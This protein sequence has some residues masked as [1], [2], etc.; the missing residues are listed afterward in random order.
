MEANQSG[1]EIHPL[2]SV[3]E[4]LSWTAP[5]DGNQLPTHLR[6][7]KFYLPGDLW[8]KSDKSWEALVSTPLEEDSRCRPKTLVC[9]DMMGG[10]LQDRFIDG[11]AEDGYHFR[12]WS[13]IDIFIYFSHHFVTIP[14]PGW[15]AA[16]RTHGVQ[17]LGTII[18]EWDAGENFS[19]RG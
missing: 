15:V 5:S 17:I 12:H 16:A 11:C 4:V 18:T 1:R 2:D 6:R 10:Y 19:A 7:S 14:P 9:H 3:E 13:N 8:A